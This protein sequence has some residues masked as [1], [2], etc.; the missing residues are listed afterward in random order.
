MVMTFISGYKSCWLAGNPVPKAHTFREDVRLPVQGGREHFCTSKRRPAQRSALGLW[1]L[2]RRIRFPPLPQ[3][4]EQGL[5]MPQ[6]LH[7]ASG[8]GQRLPLEIEL[9]I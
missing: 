8:V 4:F 6:L 5:H 7:L 9:A 2:R 3:V 1:Q